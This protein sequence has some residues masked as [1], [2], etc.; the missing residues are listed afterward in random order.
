MATNTTP[1][2]AYK[3]SFL[4]AIKIRRS[5]LALG[6]ESTISDDRIVMIVNHAIKHA[7]SPFN[8]SSCR[9]VVLLAAEH[10]KLWD[11]GLEACQK[12][13]PPPVFE[14]Y[15]P[16]LQAYHDAYG[17]VS[18]Y[19]PEISNQQLIMFLQVLFFE[20]TKALESLSPALQ[21]LVAQYPEW[22]EH[23]NA[24]NQ[25]ITWTALCVEGL[26]CNLQHVQ[27]HITPGVRATWNVPETWNLRAQLVF[28]KPTGPPRGGHDKKFVSLEERI[29][30]FGRGGV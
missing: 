23:S 14:Q 28:G 26:G 16:K 21:A 10:D 30:A 13:L 1:N 25:F 15:K 27:Q 19:K 22:A 2:S 5:T 7:P 11:I 24:M 3:V 29:M 20:D 17:T 18:H 4:D 9:A 6:K 12:N 8:V